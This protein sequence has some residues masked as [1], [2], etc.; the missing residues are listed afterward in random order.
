MKTRLMDFLWCPECHAELTL[1]VEKRE[2]EEILEGSIRCSS[3][4]ATYPIIRGIPRFFKDFKDETDLKNVY[5]HSFGFEWTSYDW[6]R[7]EDEFEFFQ[8]TDLTPEAL[9]GKTVFDAGCGGGAFFEN[10]G[11]ARRRIDRA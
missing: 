6:L 7:K 11:T 1:H 2:G 10:Y 5:A 4:H 3:C 9:S 8:I